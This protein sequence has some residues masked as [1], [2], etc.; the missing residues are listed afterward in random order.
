MAEK[1]EKKISKGELAA[2][3]VSGL[4]VLWGLTFLGIG[5]A[6][7]HLPSLYSENWVYLSESYWLTNWSGMGYR[8]WGLIITLV[9]A[10]VAVITLNVSARVSGKD[11]ERANRRKQRQLLNPVAEAEVVDAPA[12]EAPKLEEKPEDKAE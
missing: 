4:L 6:G 7:D 3:I 1:S 11:S 8:W 12:P 5:I 10:L 2:Y 9:G